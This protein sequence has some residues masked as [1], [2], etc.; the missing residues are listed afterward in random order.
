MPEWVELQRKI[1][2][3]GL[4]IASYKRLEKNCDRAITPVVEAVHVL[5]HLEPPGSLQAKQLCHLHAQLS[6]RQNCHRPKNVLHLRMQG[7]FGS[8]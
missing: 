1:G 3:R 4:L 7:H 5:A 2:Q 8:V 6:M